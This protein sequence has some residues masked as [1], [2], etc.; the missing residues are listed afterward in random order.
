MIIRTY[1][2]VPDVEENEEINVQVKDAMLFC[3]FNNL[4]I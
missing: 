2:S 4:K 3:K 1:F